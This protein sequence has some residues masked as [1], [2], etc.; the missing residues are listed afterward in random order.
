MRIIHHLAYLT[1]WAK[2]G[3]RAGLAS[4]LILLGM[5]GLVQAASLGLSQSYP[6]F[7][8]SG[9]SYSFTADGDGGLLSV[10]GAP[11]SFT[12]VAGGDQHPVSGGAFSLQADIDAAGIVLSGSLD[13]DGIVRD[14][15]NLPAILYDG[16]ADT[17]GLLG[18]GLT[19]FGFS[20]SGSTGVL[21]FGFASIDGLINSTLGPF[22]TGGMILSL[23]S[24]SF[25][26]FNAGLLNS[27]WT[28]NGYGDVF[29]TVP[30]PAAVWLFGS[31]LI[32]LLGTAVRR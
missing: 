27:N 3:R 2:P 17:N 29:A 26:D 30:V 15:N 31:G 16:T 24:S 12:Q 22:S 1:G 32:A 19:T 5:S 10:S 6:D 8:V 18:G 4:V 20:G 25:S 9:L 28:G 23:S 13:L 11:S 7:V 21:E 14:L